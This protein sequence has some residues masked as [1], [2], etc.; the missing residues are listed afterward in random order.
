M[1]PSFRKVTDDFWVAPQIT[2]ET[3]AEAARDGFR[4]ILN[5]RPDGEDPG[6][7]EGRAIAAAAAAAGIEYAEVPIRGR[8]GMDQV[9]QVAAALAEADGPV[10]AYCRS[11]MRCIAAWAMARQAAGADRDELVRL[12]YGAGY[13]L[14]Q[15]L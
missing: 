5:N 11:G 6:Q 14:S 10:L 15:L 1:N 9:E 8:P 12:G 3:A 4:L 7:P 2:P 13:D